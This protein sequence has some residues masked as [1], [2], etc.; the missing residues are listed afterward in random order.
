MFAVVTIAALALFA[1]ALSRRGAASGQT[2]RTASPSQAARPGSTVVVPPPPPMPGQAV[3][4]APSA[5]A[6]AFRTED[7]LTPAELATRQRLADLQRQTDALASDMARTSREI[8]ALEEET[9]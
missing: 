2:A 7:W 1:F 6:Q 8:E 3:T 4:I 9:P 5:P